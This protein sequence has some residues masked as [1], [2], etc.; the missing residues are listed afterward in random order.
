MIKV[1]KYV[2]HSLYSSRHEVDA[3]YDYGVVILAQRIVFGGTVA[4]AVLARKPLPEGKILTLSG[5]GDGRVLK[6]TRIPIYNQ[7]ECMANY[8]YIP[9]ELN[10]RVEFC[11]GFKHANSTSCFGDSGGPLMNGKRE[12]YGIV[13]WGDNDCQVQDYPGVYARVETMAEWFQAFMDEYK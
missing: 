11:A 10:P 6:Q 3:V 13:S 12:L 7:T 4:Q 8:G 2:S 9:I 1:L 5:W